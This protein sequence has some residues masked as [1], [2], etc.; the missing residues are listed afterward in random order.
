MV[1]H[2]IVPLHVGATYMLSVSIRVGFG[3]ISLKSDSL[4][5]EA[6]AQALKANGVKSKD[7]LPI[8]EVLKNGK[9]FSLTQA[10]TALSTMLDRLQSR[11]MICSGS[12]RWW[13]VAEGDMDAVKAGIEEMEQE[14]LRLLEELQQMYDDARSLFRER[15]TNILTTAL[16]VDEFE[17]YARK[18]PAWKEIET[19]F[20][21]EVDG[22]VK[23]PALSDLAKQEPDMQRWMKN[24][25]EQMQRDL[26]K[27]IDDACGTSA[28]FLSKLEQVDL[29]NLNHAGAEKLAKGQERLE[30]L[31]RLHDSI[32]EGL[33]DADAPVRSLI[34]LVLKTADYS[35]TL[36]TAPNLLEQYLLKLRQTLKDSELLGGAGKGAKAL[37]EWVHGVSVEQRV[38]A[39]ALGLKQFQQELPNLSQ[40]ERRIKLEE[41]KRK[42]ESQAGLMSHAATNLLA[43]LDNLLAASLQT[44]TEPAAMQL[45][46]AK[47]EAT[48]ITET[49]LESDITDLKMLEAGF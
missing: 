38:K 5:S 47:E 23:I 18:F 22:P 33:S 6:I 28:E 34:S 2:Q 49:A 36:M 7:T 45:A 41:L 21:I 8:F 9:K 35:K 46:I 48:E 39:L 30:S 26:P 14:R 12:K 20:R 29:A 11:Y 1:I 42:A 40:D 43:L 25:R 37:Y 31:L 17:A 27:L 4:K 32:C 24:V 10:G 16:R 44:Q 15:L 13:F 19:E 3:T